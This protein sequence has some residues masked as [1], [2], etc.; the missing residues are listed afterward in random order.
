MSVTRI[1]GLILAASPAPPVAV[2]EEPTLTFERDVRPI[3]KAYC[4]DCHGGEEDLEGDLDL[5]LRRFAADGGLSGPAI[6]PGHPDESLL[7]FRLEDGE[8]PPGEKKVPPDQVEVIRR[9]IAAGAPTLGDEPESLPPGIGIT[10]EERA[11]WAFQPIDAPEPPAFTAEDRVRTPIDAFVLARLREHGLSFSPD[12]DRLTLLRRA[13]ADLTGL[14]PSPG[15]IDAFLSDESPDAYDRMIDRL[16]DSPRYGERWARHWL[17][18]AGY[19]DSDGDGSTDTP[20]PYAYKYRDYV[21]RSLNGDKPLDRFIAEQLAGDELV[22]RPWTDLEPERVE[23]LAATGF[24][25]NVPDATSTGGGDLDLASNQVVADTLK[26]VGSTF[27]GLSVGCAQCHDHR[28]DPI[29][30]ADYFRLRAVFEPALDT[31]HWRRPGQRLVSLATAEEKAKAAAIEAEAQTLQEALDAKTR[32]LI[33]VELEKVLADIPEELHEALREANDTPARGRTDEQKALLVAHPKVN[34]NAGTL[35]LY[36]QKAADELKAEREAVAAKRAE[37]PPEDF[38]SV[39]DEVPDVLPETRIFHRGDHRQP[40]DPVLPGGLT[41]ASPEGGRFEIAPDDPGL[42]TSG[43]RLAFARYLVSGR[44]PMVGRVLA[45]RIWLHHFGRGLV[46]TPGDFG[47]LGERPTNPEL[48]DWLAEE[49]VRRGWSLKAMHRLIMTSTA[50]RQ[51]SLRNP[52]HDA[53]DASNALLGRYPV[54]RI[55]A[56]ALRDRILAASGRLDP[57]PFGPPVPVSEDAVGQA[58]PDGDSPRRS[59]YLQTRRSRPVSFLV[60]FDAPVMG[61]NCDRRSPSTS[62][63]QALMLMNSDFVVGEA[64]AM[65]DRLLAETPSDLELPADCDASEAVQG[66]TGATLPRLIAHAWALAYQRPIEPEELELARAFVA[67]QLDAMDSADAP[68]D[69]P[70]AAL[71]HLCHQL[72]SSNEFLYVD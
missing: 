45:N 13:S 26:V 44:H 22:P 27:L 23:T 24:L 42:P 37:K 50:Y 38:V 53:V 68:E 57:T 39:L 20:R 10:D 66:K 54:L 14:P 72:L 51:S 52:S 40:T 60:T 21:I 15:E 71:T 11:Y 47:V 59:I 5:R 41:I 65:A 49:L 36:N 35:Y 33:R 43:R 1:L 2:G 67:E 19:A 62:A 30:Q 34:V 61:V 46:N 8:M 29:P 70:R 4:L 32:E 31:Q 48:L 18:V 55:D 28:Y 7:M 63:P 64:A 3:L 12:A 17:D 25:R 16:L 58:V 69:R 6:E 9:W 56:E